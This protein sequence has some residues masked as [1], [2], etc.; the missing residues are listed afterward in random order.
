MTR[1]QKWKPFIGQQ[2]G[3]WSVIQ[4]D[5]TPEATLLRHK[6]AICRC[7]CGLEKLVCW[8]NLFYG[9]ST[10]CRPCGTR[11]LMTSHGATAY[12]HEGRLYREWKAMKWRC[13][14]KNERHADYFDRG[15]RVCEQWASSFP[16]FRD[17]AMGNNYRDDLT[18]DRR[19]NNGIY[20]PANCRWAT[21]GQQSRNHRGNRSLTAWGETKL[22]VEWSE[23]PRCGVSRWVIATRLSTGWSEEDAVTT[24]LLRK[25]KALAADSAL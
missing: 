19:D 9:K 21:T 5:G 10:G 1:A 6:K 3:N 13:S 8:P 2:F 22:L 14:Q 7:R 11:D 15:I 16:A 17:W 12:G 25:R 20:S 18:L 24:P 23:D 4:P